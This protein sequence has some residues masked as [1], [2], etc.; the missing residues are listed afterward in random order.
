MELLPVNCLFFSFTLCACAFG[1]HTMNVDMVP[2][3]RLL[4]ILQISTCS[5]PP[6]QFR[7]VT[8]SPVF[9]GATVTTLAPSE[10]YFGMFCNGHGSIKR[11][12]GSTKTSQEMWWGAG[13]VRNGF[14][15]VNLFER[16][17]AGRS[18]TF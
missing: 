18:K 13:E 3:H 17:D 8:S 1:L 2:H 9:S 12:Q 11:T 10:L 4:W 16:T 15:T 5:K 7:V 6:E 14:H